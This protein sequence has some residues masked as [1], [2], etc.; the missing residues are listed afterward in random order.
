MFYYFGPQLNII[1]NFLYTP[2]VEVYFETKIIYVGGNIHRVMYY[3]E[4]FVLDLC[5]S[6][7]AHWFKRSIISG[8][9]QTLFFLYTPFVNVY[10]ETKIISV[11][12]IF[13]EFCIF[14]DILCWTC[15]IHSQRIL[16]HRSPKRNIG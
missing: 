14:L 16:I 1:F 13:T 8:H 12:E 4:H 10:L 11:G 15:V 2:F 3:F 6:F 9:N 7:A 5:N